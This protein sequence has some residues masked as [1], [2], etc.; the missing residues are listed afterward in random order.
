MRAALLPANLKR[1]RCLCRDNALVFTAAVLIGSIASIALL[2]ST[3]RQMIQNVPTLSASSIV[4]PAPLSPGKISGY[5][6]LVQTSLEPPERL[7]SHPD[8]AF[9]PSSLNDEGLFEIHVDT[10]QT[11]QEIIG[12]GGAITDAT[13][14][15]LYSLPKE[16]QDWILQQYFGQDGIGFSVSRVHMTSCD[17][18]PKAYTHADTYFDFE[19]DHFD[20][21]VSHD[22]WTMI[23]MFQRVQKILTQQGKELLVQAAPWSPPAW[24]KVNGMM[25]R[26]PDDF[27]II[28]L[29]AY[30]RAWAHYISKFVAAYKAKGVKIWSISPQNEPRNTASPWEACCYKVESMAQFIAEYLGPVMR[31]EH[32]EVAIY[33][34]DDNKEL[35]YNPAS[36]GRW[37]EMFQSVAAP[38]LTGISLHWYSGDNFDSL[39]RFHRA[40]PDSVIFS[41]EHTYE[42]SRWKKGTNI[43]SGD[44]SFGMGYAHD[45][46]GD[47]NAGSSGWL[48]WN[49]LLDA[50][51]GPNRFRN[52]CD[53]PMMFDKKTGA[54]HLH[55]Q[56]Y[57]MGHFSKFITRGAKRL[58]SVHTLGASFVDPRRPYGSC[59]AEDGLQA[60]AALRPDG[61]VALVVLN[62]GSSTTKFKIRDGGRSITT[63]IPGQAVQTYLFPAGSEGSEPGI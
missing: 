24:M 4:C 38:Y 19:L 7:R 35:L 40:F 30:L 49:L 14:N 22:E 61:I 56:F 46:I 36:W 8:L 44:W 32:A 50:H 51:G 55:P 29:P 26:S 3:F 5:A 45:I 21:N 37:A 12:F 6:K 54:V 27:C 1:E 25:E 18:S 10:S 52:Y 17:F 53:S 11:D 20:V 16:T 48:T 63:C 58:A 42:Q 47:L 31:A 57:F 28:W 34:L 39:E 43:S 2:S 13:A 33:T 15:N 9:G 59:T 23:P 60:T 41:S 62:C